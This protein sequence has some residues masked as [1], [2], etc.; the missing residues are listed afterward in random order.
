MKRIHITIFVILFSF[1]LWSASQTL[2][3]ILNTIENNNLTLKAFHQLGESEKVSNKVGIAPSNPSVD[4]TYAW[5][6]P[7]MGNKIALSASQNFYFPSV[8]VRKSQIANLRNDQVDLNYQI[9][10][11]EILGAAAQVCNEIIFYNALLQDLEKCAKNITGLSEI[12]KKKLDA[13]SC[14]IFEY[15]KF[16][17]N[18][19]NIEQEI[20]LK[21]IE[22]DA[23]L[24]NLIT[25]NGGVPI[26]ISQNEI[27]I[28][29]F[30]KDFEVWYQ[31][32]EQ[33][34]PLLQIQNKEIEVSK[35][36]VQ[37]AQGMYAPQFKVGYALEHLPSEQFSGITAGISIPLWEN[38]NSV[39]HSQAQRIATQA[40]AYDSKTQFYNEMKTIHAR[41]IALL[42]ISQ[43]YRESIVQIEN[44]DHITRALE[45]GEISIEE[46]FL[47]Y[48]AFHDSHVTLLNIMLE[49][50]QCRAK[51]QLYE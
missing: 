35:R 39:K 3:Q 8:Y 14:N 44:L 40:I 26:E 17:I 50:V 19:L 48:S 23:L 33:K 27:I 46:F 31:N 47:E 37:L 28:D 34:N 29:N 5:G 49:A 32:A 11:N 38:L 51:L 24:R 18:A 20:I 4:F 6:S 36:Q 16:K 25:L 9:K 45:S 2:N 21:K 43:E 41:L 12:Y 13:G 42:Q 15:N 22:R 1:P 7:N 10:R 30:E